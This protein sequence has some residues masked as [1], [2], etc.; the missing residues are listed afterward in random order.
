MKIIF[1]HEIKE[2][3]EVE[4]II[5]LILKKRQIAD[6]KEFLNPPSPL[7][8][9]LNFFHS[10]FENLFKKTLEI[11]QEVKEK[12]QM[13][14]VYTDY[15]ADG[16][17][18][19]AILWETL[20][21]LGFKVMPYV[22]DRKKEGYGFSIRGIDNVIKKF[23]PSL[24]ISVDHGI[25]K[26]KEVRYLKEK[27][28]KVIIT[29]HHLKTDKVPQADAIF[30]IPSLSGSG[31]AYFFA[32]EIYQTL[33]LKIKNKENLKLLENNFSLDYQVLSSIGTIADLVALIGPSRSLVKYGL[34]SFL[35]TKRVGIKHILKEA[36]IEKRKITPYEVGFIIAPRINAVGRL[37]NALDALRLLCT[38]KE[39]RA[40]QLASYVGEKNRQRQDILEKAVK[41]AE[42]MVKKTS[43]G[44]SQEKLIILKKENWHEGIIGLIASKIAEEFYRPTIV[45]TKT[46]GIYKASARSIPSFHITNFLRQFK[47]YLIDVGGH[48]QASGFTLNQGNLEKFI[49]ESVKMA[50][51]EI[52]DKD[53]ERK[54]YVD[55]KIPLKLVT[56]DLAKELEKL[57][58]FGIGNPQP[59]FLSKGKI[60]AAK[61]F[62]KKNEHLKLFIKSI[63]DFPSS[64]LSKNH[65]SASSAALEF[66]FFNQASLF[67]RLSRDQEVKIIYTLEVDRWGEK[68]N[69]RGKVIKIIDN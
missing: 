57:Y 59:V 45:L 19:G 26:V 48:E 64:L 20:Y 69:I 49:E 61:I 6:L 38:K 10:S 36:G 15:D 50:Q 2:K 21:L 14:V 53:L 68:E 17:T 67:P 66:L 5:N 42:N 22:P 29:D 24:I 52:K 41:E 9:N 28:I 4:E 18:G 39:E 63:D 56:L 30:H 47:K 35:K 55:L 11:L 32:K 60:H 37:E 54:I 33:K 46:D 12:N 31:V 43:E 8:Y 25:T 3:L 7:I 65:L 13:I 40:F 1:G 51:E 34:E 16:I 62:G 23:N 58:P 27:G 44:E